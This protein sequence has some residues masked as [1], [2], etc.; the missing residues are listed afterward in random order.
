[1][2]QA[3]TARRAIAPAT[4]ST[5]ERLVTAAIRLFQE[6]GYHG[7]GV[8]EILAAA[9]S[10]KGS[11]Y[12]HFPGGKPELAVTAIARITADVEASLTRQ[13]RKGASAADLVRGL[14]QSQARWLRATDWRQ[15]SLFVSLAQGFI[16]EAPAVTEALARHA[17]HRRA[18]LAR[19]LAEDGVAAAEDMAALALAALDGALLEARLQRDVAPLLAVADRLARLA[20]ARP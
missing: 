13:R 10:P 4:A 18:L 14:A 9:Q 12:H 2:A 1:M 19:A 17:R 7:A 5:R 16:P 8:A 20:E 11:L 6:R 15:A 3:A